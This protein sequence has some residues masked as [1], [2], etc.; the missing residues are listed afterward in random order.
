MKIPMVENLTV[1]SRVMTSTAATNFNNLM[2][3]IKCPAE[4]GQL[5][6]PNTVGWSR[7]EASAVTSETSTL[8]IE[9]GSE[10]SVTYPS[11]VVNRYILADTVTQMTGV[12][13]SRTFNLSCMTQ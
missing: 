12:V 9:G 1:K 5:G 3:S 10:L 6:K 4:E 7:S 13:R 11:G 2:R 8:D